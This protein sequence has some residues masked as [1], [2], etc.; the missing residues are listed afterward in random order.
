M[1]RAHS[2]KTDVEG[3]WKDWYIE[4]SSIICA[5]A[6]TDVWNPCIKC[7]HAAYSQLSLTQ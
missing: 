7:G 6:F 3:K 1:P 4:G 2:A 5:S